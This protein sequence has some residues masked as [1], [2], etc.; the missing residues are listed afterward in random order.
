MNEMA[1]S[2][3]QRNQQSGRLDEDSRVTVLNSFLAKLDLL[4]ERCHS[5]GGKLHE[6]S[7][8]HYLSIP[9]TKTWFTT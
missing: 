8:V 4:S 5:L 9:F 3:K 1:F 2:T 6:S 7:A